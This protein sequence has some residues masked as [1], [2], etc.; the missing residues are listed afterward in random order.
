MHKLLMWKLQKQ[1]E[2]VYPERN[3]ECDIPDI[4]KI[5]KADTLKFLEPAFE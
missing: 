2:K 5:S 3:G 1:S 4:L